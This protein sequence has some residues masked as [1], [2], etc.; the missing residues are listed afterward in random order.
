MKRIKLALLLYL[1]FVLVLGPLYAHVHDAHSEHDDHALDC[2]E[3]DGHKYAY[4]ALSFL[5]KLGHDC[6]CD[7]HLI[8]ISVPEILSP[9]NCFNDNES[10]N[11][12][13]TF[14]A[15]STVNENIASR[16]H[17]ALHLKPP[18]WRNTEPIYFL[19]QRIRI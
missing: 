7:Y 15:I 5:P 11:H 2:H 10:S 8:N 14:I 16:A 4:V 9:E 17:V 18:P 3:V 13:Q 1:S 6:C 12:D 19:T